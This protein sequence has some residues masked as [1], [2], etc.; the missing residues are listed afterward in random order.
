MEPTHFHTLSRHRNQRILQLSFQMFHLLT[1]RGLTLSLSTRFFSVLGRMLLMCDTSWL[2]QLFV[3]TEDW[4][5]CEVSTPLCSARPHRRA[6]Q[7]HRR[8][9]VR[10]FCKY[11]NCFLLRMKILNRRE[12]D[13]TYSYASLSSCDI[14]RFGDSLQSPKT[15]FPD[16]AT[17]INGARSGP[18]HS[19]ENLQEQPLSILTLSAK[20]HSR[21]VLTFF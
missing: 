17:N 3:Y 15:V 7:Y 12:L 1:C 16:K 4:R 2:L 13:A 18:K 10:T 6:V 14:L 9:S 19:N 8:E 21:P 20:P 11:S 5:R